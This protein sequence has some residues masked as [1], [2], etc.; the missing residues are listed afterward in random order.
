MVTSRW[1]LKAVKV[2][3]EVQEVRVDPD[4]EDLSPLRTKT[5]IICSIDVA[6]LIIIRILLSIF[7][8]IECH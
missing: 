1:S 2:V 6:E 8:V 4:K 5:T 7:T 3:R